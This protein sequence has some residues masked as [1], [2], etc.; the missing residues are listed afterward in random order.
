MNKE[1]ES[2]TSFGEIRITGP[3]K[4]LDMGTASPGKVSIDDY[5]IFDAVGW[6]YGGV[7]RLSRI[8]SM[9]DIAWKPRPVSGQENEQEGGNTVDKRPSR[10]Y[11]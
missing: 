2:G 5:R 3:A 6:Y 10:V 4:L 11:E 7:S 1:T 9:L 8:D